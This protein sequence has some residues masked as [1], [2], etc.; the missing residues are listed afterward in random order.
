M[1][2]KQNKNGIEMTTNQ[3]DAA[4]PNA[5]SYLLAQ[6]N[7]VEQS[8]RSREEAEMEWRTGSDASWRQVGCKRTKSE[9][10]TIANREAAILVK[11]RRELITLRTILEMLEQS[12]QGGG[13]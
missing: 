7:K 13:E 1:R 11:L 12:Q 4:L 2:S 3:K 6:I 5:T 10:I 9:R 8:I